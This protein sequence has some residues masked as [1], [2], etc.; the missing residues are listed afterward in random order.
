MSI[1]A[2]IANTL[3]SLFVVTCRLLSVSAAISRIG[4]LEPFRIR[5][6]RFLWTGMFVSMV[7]DGFYFVATAWQVYNLSNRPSSLAFVGLAWSLPQFLFVFIAGALADRLDRR[8]LMIAGDL[9]RSVAIVTIGILS[10]A[11]VLTIPTMVALVVFYG[12]GQA[13]FQPSFHSIVPMIVPP[14]QLVR[15]NS[16]DQFVRPFAL[17]VVGP[18]LGGIIVGSFGAGWAFIADGAT[19]LFSAAMIFAMSNRTVERDEEET[20]SLWADMKEGLSFVR[21]TR[22]LMVMFGASVLSL[23][24]VWGPWETLMPFVVRNELDAGAGGLGL[25]FAAGGI[26]AV[27]VA[28]TL[29]Q[30]GSLPKRALAVVYVAWSIGMFATAGFGVVT[31]LWQAMIVSLIAEAAI[32]A[33]VIVWY[34]ILQR[35]VPGS[36]LGR[37]TSLDWMITI[38]GVPLSFAVVGPVADSI[39]AQTTLVVAGVLG[40]VITLGAMFVPGARGPERDGSLDVK[41]MAKEQV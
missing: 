28:I 4:I 38:A 34:T 7:G 6:F 32:S 21:K 11:G 26:G 24:A 35:L 20:T 33:V 13:L 22:W 39:G 41:E 8:M 23:F 27:A 14:E 5:D 3:D 36:L 25:V 30:R 1:A 29:G 31:H 2:R 9:L 18:A 40:G 15:A 10:V 37:I 17:M 12:I 19:F 16:V